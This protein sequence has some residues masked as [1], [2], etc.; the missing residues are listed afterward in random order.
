MPLYA[1]PS[2]PPT[3]YIEPN[4]Q[5]DF[6]WPITP[7]L[8]HQKHWHII[9]IANASVRGEDNEYTNKK[10][11]RERI[12]AFNMA[13]FV[14]HQKGTELFFQA[15]CF[16]PKFDVHDKDAAVVDIIAFHSWP[17]ISLTIH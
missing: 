17:S 15:I 9:D 1:I 4:E 14:F 12:K 13:V 10:R 6:M 7:P 8:S 5:V 16:T 11:E 2:L 3:C